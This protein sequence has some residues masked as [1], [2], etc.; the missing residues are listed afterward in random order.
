MKANK[1]QKPRIGR[2]APEGRKV[3]VCIKLIPMLQAWAKANGGP[4]AAADKGLRLLPGF[5]KFEK[6]WKGGAK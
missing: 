4:S 1:P 3:P 5:G 6:Q 2:P